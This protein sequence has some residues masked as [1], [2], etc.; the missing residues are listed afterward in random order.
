MLNKANIFGFPLVIFA[1]IIDQ[2]YRD[3][4]IL[5]NEPFVK[6]ILALCALIGIG[7]LWSEYP[8]FGHMKWRKYFILLIFIPFFSLLNKER[9][10]WAIAGLLMGY[11]SILLIGGFESLILS[12]QGIPQLNISYLSFSAQLGIGAILS[13]YLAQANSENKEKALFFMMLGIV[14]LFLQFTQNA[15]AVLLATLIAIAVM[16]WFFYS[17]N[18]KKYA[19]FLISLLMITVIFSTITPIFRDR[20]IQI[21]DD[22]I[23]FHQGNYN[24]SIGSRVA[25]WDIGIDGIRKSPLLG[26]G[27]GTPEIY[28]QKEVKVYKDGQYKNLPN[29]L[30]VTHYHND[31]IEIGMHLGIVGIFALGFLLWS[32]YQTFKVH[33]LR[34][35]GIGLMCYI[36]IAGLTDTFIIFSRISTFLLVVTAISIC[37]SKQQHDDKKTMVS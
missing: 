11:F 2:G 12:E 33:A 17:K 23:E 32:W 31:W 8:F 22:V 6:G 3:F 16:T 4:S 10:L 20:L 29:F 30:E 35:L 14:L 26:H 24:T 1:W 15:R 18:I 34:N 9:L 5:L 13:I 19:F 27:T 28:F 21:K 7:L 36:F 37:W 25:L